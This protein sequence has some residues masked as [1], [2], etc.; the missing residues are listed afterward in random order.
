VRLG[1]PAHQC[2]RGQPGSIGLGHPVAHQR[3][4]SLT[5]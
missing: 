1:H 5:P 2:T 3:N 4:A